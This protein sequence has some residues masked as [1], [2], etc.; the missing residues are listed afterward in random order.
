V[1]T[2]AAEGS[3]ASR[4]ESLVVRAARGDQAAFDALVP[5]RLDRCYRIAWS[6]LQNE[7]DAAD[8]TQD[9][10]VSAWR[11]LPRLREV[12]AFDGWLNRIVANASYT[13][14]RRR[15]RLREVQPTLVLDDPQG[16]IEAAPDHITE[17]DTI[18]ER[19]SVRRAFGRIRPAERQILVLHHVDG[20]PVGEIARSL[21]IP[22]GTVKSRLHAARKAFE[23]AME[24]EA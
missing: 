20:R 5:S 1:D 3:G 22:E 11:T 15:I 14:L 6:I 24:V 8:A 21:G 13:V 4:E 17:S 9:A 10:F 7:A 23:Q 18:V 12:A 19:D 2:V 16:D